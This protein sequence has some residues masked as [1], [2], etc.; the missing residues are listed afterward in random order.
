MNFPFYMFLLNIVLSQT[1]IDEDLKGK[2][3]LVA[4]IYLTRDRLNKDEV[5]LY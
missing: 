5:L 3:K 2:A 1:F 4:C